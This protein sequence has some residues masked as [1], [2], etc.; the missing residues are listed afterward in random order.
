M[1]TKCAKFKMGNWVISHISFKQICKKV[2]MIST[3]VLFNAI[4]VAY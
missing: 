4:K 1:P 2:Q 3:F